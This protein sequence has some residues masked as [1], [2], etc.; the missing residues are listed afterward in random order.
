[1]LFSMAGTRPDPA[2]SVPS[3]KPAMP[4]A[5]AVAEPEEEPPGTQSGTTGL[6]GVPCG[7]RVPF[8][9]VANWSRLALPSS[10]APA[11]SSRATT[12]ASSA[13]V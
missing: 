1:M 4:E 3:E 12:G 10:M 2:V 11:A 13:G 5:T 6:R 8:S 9:P 7:L